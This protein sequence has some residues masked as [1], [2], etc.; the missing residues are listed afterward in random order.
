MAK[1]RLI[2]SGTGFPTLEDLKRKIPPGGLLNA[3]LRKG[4]TGKIVTAKELF[5]KGK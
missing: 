2:K 3:G 5:K 1:R 4:T